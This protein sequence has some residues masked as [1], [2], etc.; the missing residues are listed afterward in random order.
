[1]ATIAKTAQKDP[2]QP[3]PKKGRCCLEAKQPARGEDEVRS[4]R[5]FRHDRRQRGMGG[6][7]I[8]AEDL[9]LGLLILVLPG[10][11]YRCPKCGYKQG[12]TGV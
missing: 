4:L 5:P 10:W 6:M 12:M 11:S 9:S 1:M 2:P 3:G 8:V 7:Q